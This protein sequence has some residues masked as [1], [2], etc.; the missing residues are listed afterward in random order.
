M[1]ALTIGK[2]A[3]SAG[4]GVET[5]RFY[6]R[7]GLIRQPPRPSGSAFRWQRPPACSRFWKRPARAARTCRHRQKPSAVKYR[8]R[9]KV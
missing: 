9:S 5:I 7:K 1:A 4:I 2:A 3:R 6:E 8:P